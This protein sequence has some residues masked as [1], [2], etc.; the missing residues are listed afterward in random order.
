M[1]CEEIC[2]GTH[3]L[4]GAVATLIGQLK[5]FDPEPKGIVEREKK[6][7]DTSFLHER[8]LNNAQDSN[9]QLQH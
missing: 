3:F 5:H 9:S 7:L 6:Y 4:T 8:V 1:A 2:L